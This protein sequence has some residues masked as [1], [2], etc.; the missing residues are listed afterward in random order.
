MADVESAQAVRRMTASEVSKLN[1]ANARRALATLIAGD[2]EGS[3][4][5]SNAVF[6]NELKEMRKELGQM[7]TMKLQVQALSEKLDCAFEII[8]QQQ[9]FL[10]SVDAK[11]RWR[12]LVIT[13]VSEGEDGLGATDEEKIKAVVMASGYNGELQVSE[14]TVKRLGQANEER[15]R[16]MLI[17][18]SNKKQRDDIV[19]GARGLKNSERFS[20]IYIKK[21]IH[22]A[23]RKEL[24]RLRARE[25]DEKNKPENAGVNIHY[26]W[27]QRVL[28]RDEVIIDRYCPIF[29]SVGGQR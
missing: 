29:Y 6:L 13:G 22:P 5:L 15:R 24:A 26:D 1:A 9:R 7:K 8:N 12:N 10:E 25:R 19:S 14:W 4:D 11:E 16:P 23:S 27:K 28:L 18:T 2:P 21:D 17:T 3:D 20:R